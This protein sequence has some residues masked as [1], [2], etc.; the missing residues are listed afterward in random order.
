MIDLD[1]QGC[2]R[3][4]PRRCVLVIEDWRF[5]GEVLSSKPTSPLLRSKYEVTLR[6]GSLKGHPLEAQR[7]PNHEANSPNVV[8]VPGA[9]Q[10]LDRYG[11]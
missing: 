7:V 3:S 4:P 10:P 1:G 8:I 11:E 2:L 6:L 5:L 9:C